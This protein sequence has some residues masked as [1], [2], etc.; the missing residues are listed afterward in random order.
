MAKSKVDRLALKLKSFASVCQ[1]TSYPRI[2][3]RND[4]ARERK[5]KNEGGNRV[6]ARHYGS[7]HQPPTSN[8]KETAKLPLKFSTHIPQEYWD[9]LFESA[10]LALD[11]APQE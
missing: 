10:I 4:S 9:Q 6:T 8:F 2:P 11:H 5:L 3:C 7:L 1:S